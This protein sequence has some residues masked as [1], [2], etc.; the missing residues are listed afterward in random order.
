MYLDSVWTSKWLILTLGIL[1][2]FELYPD[3]IPEIQE[4]LLDFEKFAKPI[5]YILINLQVLDMGTVQVLETIQYSSFDLS[6]SSIVA[7]LGD[8]AVLLLQNLRTQLLKYFISLDAE[9]A[10]GI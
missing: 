10:I 2:L 7:V 1:A 3:K 8:I 6:L 9:N 4:F 5:M